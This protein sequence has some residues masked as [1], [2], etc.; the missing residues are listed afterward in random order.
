MWR[1]VNE[2]VV[3][4]MMNY[5]AMMLTSYWVNY[6]FKRP[7]SSWPETVAIQESA[8]MSYLFPLTRFNN[9]FFMSMMFMLV[10]L[11]VVRRTQAGYESRMVGLNPKA[12]TIAG[13]EPGK[14]ML[15]AMLV[16]GGALGGLAG[17]MEVTGGT[18]Y[19][20]M[21]SFSPGFGMTGILIALVAQNDPIRVAIVAFI[22]AFMK[23]G[24]ASGIE[25]ATDVPAEI[26]DILQT[27]IVLSL[28]LS[29]VCDQCSMKGFK[30]R[31]RR[32]GAAMNMLSIGT[33]LGRL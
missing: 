8:R 12:S 7:G 1:G 13:I 22:F 6:P 5:V 15:K 2:V 19:R 3:T 17:G 4:L 33:V 29:A 9:T 11:F 28:Q 32:G 20:F 21:D 30:G 10:V 25:L 24:G 16:S 31:R 27:L 14:T 23:N 26:C 18:M